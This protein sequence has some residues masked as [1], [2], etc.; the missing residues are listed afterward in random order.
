MASPNTGRKESKDSDDLYNTPLAA[1]DAAWEEG[2]FDQYDVYYD[3]CDGL[4][5]ISDFLES[6]GKK[7]Y[8]GDLVD[9]DRNVDIGDFLDKTELPSEEIQ[10]IVFNPP[11]KLSEEFI[12]K[13][14]ALCGEVIMFNRATILETKSR[15]EKH[16]SGAWPLRNFW[17]FANRVSCTKGVNK[18]PT[19]N[20]VWYGWFHYSFE[21]N[22]LFPQIRWLKTKK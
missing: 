6:K 3:P 19:A 20:S 22:R 16:S 8:R 15:S 10:C 9:Y 17:S 21:S 7:V 5:A 12:D 4:G 13:A 1:L 18:E 2:I 11:F 14:L